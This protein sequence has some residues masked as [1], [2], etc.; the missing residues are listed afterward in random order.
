MQTQNQ[1]IIEYFRKHGELTRL[2]ALV[3][4]SVADLPK[5]V[6]ELKAK[7]YKIESV[8]KSKKNRYGRKVT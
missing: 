3:K 5:R 7:G 8:K 6:T 1:R 4:L 2:T